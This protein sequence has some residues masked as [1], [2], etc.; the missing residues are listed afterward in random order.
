M[1]TTTTTYLKYSEL[2]TDEA[3]E[4]AAEETAQMLAEAIESDD[5]ECVIIESIGFDLGQHEGGQENPL[6]GIRVAEWSVGSYDDHV[7]IEGMLTAET[8][9]KLPWPPG[10][11]YARFGRTNRE[12][13][14]NDRDLWLDNSEGGTEWMAEPDDEGVEAFWD[15]VDD[16]LADA[17]KA[18]QTEQEYMCSTGYANDW[19]DANDPESFDAEGHRI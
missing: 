18:G 17:L 6:R 7:S 15:A 8:A 5:I 12:W 2:T 16:V 3:R 13:T 4:T 14:G 9:P 11:T 1:R 10:C 19:L